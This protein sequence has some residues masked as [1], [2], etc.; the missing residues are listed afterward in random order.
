MHKAYLYFLFYTKAESMST[1]ATQLNSTQL[2]WPVNEL[3]W[4]VSRG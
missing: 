3:S 1:D 4:V 2:N